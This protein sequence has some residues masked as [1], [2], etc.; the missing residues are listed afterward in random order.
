[1][2]SKCTHGWPEV[3]AHVNGNPIT[4]FVHHPELYG[5]LISMR[6]MR[7]GC[8][9]IFTRTTVPDTL[10][11]ALSIFTSY[12]VTEYRPL[13]EREIPRFPYSGREKIIN[14]FLLLFPFRFNHNEPPP[15]IATSKLLSSHIPAQ[16]TSSSPLLLK[17]LKV[18]M[19]YTRKRTALV[20]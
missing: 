11:Y 14:S 10:C 8:A 19:Q 4:V 7:R 15:L 9:S 2:H 20:K 18:N 12:R 5:W 13:I 6:W 17:A 16:T 1:M 3:N